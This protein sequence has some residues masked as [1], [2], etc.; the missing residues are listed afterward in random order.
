M[1]I[2]NAV[3]NSS[4]VEATSRMAPPEFQEQE[5]HASDI[6]VVAPD[7]LAFKA[8]EE[9]FMNER[10]EILIEPG[11]EPNDP[12]YVELGHQGIKQMVKRGV[13]QIVKRKYLYVAL[14]GKKV[15]MQCSFGMAADG[16]EYN[17][18]T[19]AVAGTYR[20]SLL[21]DPNPQGGAK[22]VQSVMAESA[23]MH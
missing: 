12:V 5:F 4:D 13:P 2:K 7:R 16:K 14:M 8:A 1:R 19:P 17:K 11:T 9:K 23:G 6:Q 15:S 10:V 18:L 21:S 3:I 22:W 20:T